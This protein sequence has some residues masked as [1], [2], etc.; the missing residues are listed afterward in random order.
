MYLE[1]KSFFSNKIIRLVLIISIILSIFMVYNIFENGD[2]SEGAIN[3]LRQEIVTDKKY[4]DDKITS[5]EMYT[6][7]KYR[8]LKDEYIKSKDWEI[9]TQ[10][11]RLD[12]YLDGYRKNEQELRK[13]SIYF[14]LYYMAIQTDY[15]RGY[16]Y[17]TQVFKDEIENYLDLSELPFDLYALEDLHNVSWSNVNSFIRKEIDR[18]EL[19]DGYE[20]NKKKLERDFFLYKNN[21]REVDNK[22]LSPW[23]YLAFTYSFKLN[24]VQLFVPLLIMLSTYMLI[25]SRKEKS[26]DLIKLKADKKSK[27]Y[28]H[29]LK[30]ILSLCLI[31]L[32]VP[33]LLAI[34]FMGIKNGFYGLKNP[35]GMY[36]EGLKSLYP[37]ENISSGA[38]IRGLGL[39]VGTGFN[40][41]GHLIDFLG[42]TNI[43]FYKFLLL[44]TVPSILKLVFFISLGVSI[45]LLIKNN[46]ISL[47]VS[48][49][50]TLFT[51]LSANLY[52][53]KTPYNI[54][55]FDS[56][57]NI[58][59]GHT[60]FS[61]LGSVLGLSIGIIIVVS[62]SLLVLNKKELD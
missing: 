61:W 29:Y 11:R 26:L 38:S 10:E 37:Y 32:L 36:V 12:L 55:S 17:P 40:S 39:I 6:P 52:G 45:G 8:Y 18:E 20:V 21:L 34:L 49:L 53:L 22:S 42:L 62:V 16:E 47:L 4:Y 2:R 27:I 43:E 23:T 19:H 25:Y 13:L 15:E 1:L 14:N 24:K 59:L 5:I 33:D 58:T 46:T 30:I 7:D 51:V 44:S 60:N 54:F 57:W 9:E 28:T 3:Y 48:S 35:I 50:I 31:I 56:G 41:L